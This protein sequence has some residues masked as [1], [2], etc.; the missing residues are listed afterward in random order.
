MNP[1]LRN[2]ISDSRIA[3]GVRDGFARASC[4]WRIRCRLRSQFQFVQNVET[5]A[6]RKRKHARRNFVESISANLFAT[7]QTKRVA[8]ARE[9]QAQVIIDFRGRR[10]GRARIARGIFLA[11][12]NGRGDAGDFVHVRL[13]DSFEKLPRV[14]GKR[15]DVTPLAFGVKRVEREAGLARTGNARHDRDRVVR[16][17]EIDVLQVVYTSA[18]D[19]DLLDIAGDPA[20]PRVARTSSGQLLCGFR[21][22]VRKPKIIRRRVKPSKSRFGGFRT[23]CEAL[24]DLAESEQRT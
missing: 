6:G 15:L 19:A 12:R 1:R 7:A 8:D 4:L 16:N 13:L 14:G 20:G 22:H 23:V 9:Q 5:A 10:N 3:S 17:D 24:S 21:R 11:D 18:A 2:L